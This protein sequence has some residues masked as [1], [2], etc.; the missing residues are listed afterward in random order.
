[1]NI[2][3]VVDG[4]EESGSPTFRSW[5]AE[6]VHRLRADFAVVSEL[7]FHDGNVP[8]ITSSLRGIVSLHIEV[9]TGHGELLAGNFAGAVQNPANALAHVLAGLVDRNGRITIPGVLDDVAALDPAVRTSLAATP[10]DAPAFRRSAGVTS[11]GD[12]RWSVLES[13]TGRPALDVNGLHA[14]FTGPG[15]KA[16]IPARASAKVSIRLVPNQIPERVAHL[17]V[18]HLKRA[19]PPDTH[20]RT[21][22][23]LLSPP[24]RMDAEHPAISAALAALRTSF[25]REPVQLH[26]GGSLPVLGVMTE[27]LGLPVMSMGFMQP[28]SNEHAPN[29][30][31]L[32]DNFERGTRAI[33]LFCAEL[34]ASGRPSPEASPSPHDVDRDR[35]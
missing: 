23:E 34:G 4:E 26:G 33:A 32:E 27:T 8:A 18:E 29:E 13:R 19:A 9:E 11:F 14:G 5:A 1:M 12:P 21:T 35:S 6:H 10:F 2:T 31:L 28:G 30:W 20:I 24:T 16:V 3:F 7:G 15:P 17:V 22:I 25:E